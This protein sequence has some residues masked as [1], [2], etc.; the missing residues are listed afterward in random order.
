MAHVKGQ[1]G[2]PPPITRRERARRT[3]T[4]IIRSAHELFV[5]RGYSGATMADIAQAAGVAVQT[6]YFTFHTKPELLHA[7]YEAA[8][9]GTEDPVPPPQQ[10]WYRNALAATTGAAALQAFTIGVTGI[11]ARV[12]ALD[13]VVRSAL[14]EPEAVAVRERAEE[15]RRRGFST[16]VEHLD[17]RFGLRK[18]LNVHE[19]TDLLMMLVGPSVYRTLVLDYGWSLDRFNSWLADTAATQLLRQPAGSSRRSQRQ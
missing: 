19:A 16:I 18:G 9:L 12:G 3:R 10:P 13:D 11:S 8:V 14:H 1:D 7:C 4:A 15:L 6:V 17:N 5:T 2:T